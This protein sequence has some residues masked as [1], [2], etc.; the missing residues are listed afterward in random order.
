MEPKAGAYPVVTLVPIFC[1]NC[2]DVRG[3]EAPQRPMARPLRAPENP[4]K[5]PHTD[6]GL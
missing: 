5:R 2:G 3:R 6:L 4:P 1:G